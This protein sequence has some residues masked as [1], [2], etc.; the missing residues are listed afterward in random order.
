MVRTLI[1]T[2]FIPLVT[3]ILEWNRWYLMIFLPRSG[4]HIHLNRP[5]LGKKVENWWKLSKQLKLPWSFD[6]TADPAVIVSSPLRSFAVETTCF[7]LSH[8]RASIN[9]CTVKMVLTIMEHPWTSQKNVHYFRG[10]PILGSLD[11]WKSGCLS[12][13]YIPY[14]WL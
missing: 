6:S 11:V 9:G 8:V 14:V 2:G 12:I 13:P 7:I 5:H 1:T 4:N 10:Y 3:S